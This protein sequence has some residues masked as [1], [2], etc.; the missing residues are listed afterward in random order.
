M[1][2][3]IL[4]ICGHP[5]KESFCSA[6]AQSYAQGAK[7]SGAEVR[8]HH[9]VDC[10]FDPILWRAYL[11][12]QSLEPDL[13]TIQDDI[14]WADHVIFNYP[15]WWGVPPTLM[16]G[17]FDRTFHPGFAFT[18]EPGKLMQTKLLKGRSSRVICTMDS[19]PWYF[20]WLIGA[21]GHKMLKNSVLKFCGFSPVKITG[22]GSVKH[23][24]PE[25]RKK[26]LDKVHALGEKQR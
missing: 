15:V 17:F 1:I 4:I 7:S 6:L 8:L 24:S 3:K 12:I 20:R 16:K 21:P 19:P 25:K 18:F 23:S 14:K 5:V 22:I 9:L 26:W 2:K 10:E 11:E 13:L